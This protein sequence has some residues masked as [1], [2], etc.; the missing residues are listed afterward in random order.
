[1]GQGLIPAD[2]EVWKIRRRAIVPALHRQYLNSMLNMFGECSL[3][4]AAV[5]SKA[6]EVGCGRWV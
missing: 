5:L 4:G 6:A 1:M 3:H 2:G